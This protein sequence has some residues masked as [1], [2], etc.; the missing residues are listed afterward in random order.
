MFIKIIWKRRKKHLVVVI[1]DRSPQSKESNTVVLES[2]LQGSTMNVEVKSIYDT[3]KWEKLIMSS[4][5]LI[6]GQEITVS[7]SLNSTNLCWA[8][9]CSWCYSRFQDS[10]A[11]KVKVPALRT[12]ALIGHSMCFYMSCPLCCE[13]LKDGAV[14]HFSLYL[15]CLSLCL[16]CK[17]LLNETS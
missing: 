7:Q 10:A 4:G 5:S 6:I 15:K 14:F 17:C 13:F 9:L 3:G 16:A 1:G 2:H 8:P 11:N 12:S